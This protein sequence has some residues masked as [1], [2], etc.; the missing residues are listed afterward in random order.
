MAGGVTLSSYGHIRAFLF[1]KDGTLIDYERSWGPVNRRAV[2]VLSG[3]DMDLEGRLLEAG[4]VDRLSGLTR[5]DSVFAS[6]STVDVARAFMAVGLE[7][8]ELE[9]VDELDVIFS[10][11]LRTAVAVTDLAVFFGMLRSLGLR[12]GVASNDSEEGIRRFLDY[13]GIVGLVDFVSGYDSGYGSKPGSGMFRGFCGSVGVGGGEAAMVGDTLHDM[14][15]GEGGG[16]G[17]LVGV[18]TG[19]GTRE[20]LAPV[21]D[22]CLDSVADILPLLGV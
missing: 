4:G 17:L 3:G 22:I 20:V 9:L 16:A 1:D 5:S 6:G 13:F 11:V 12:T 2:R 21:S 15:C 14:A 18:L 10:E 7:R 8:D 19:T